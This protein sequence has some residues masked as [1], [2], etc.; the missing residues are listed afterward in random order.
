MAIRPED[1]TLVREHGVPTSPDSTFVTLLADGSISFTERGAELYRFALTWHG[2]S[3]SLLDSV[4]TL[5]QLREL[6]LE[7]KK[8]RVSCE[9]EA[10]E[11]ALKQGRV[12]HK[13][14]ETLRAVL[15]G[16]TEDIRRA[17]AR[18]KA[19][20]A[21]GDNVIPVAFGLRA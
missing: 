9:S 7:I 16:S 21:A 11:R 4:H 17:V 20:E 8:T 10:A 13:S 1:A 12:P 3:P 19:C 18:R 6:S 15:H 2:L 5:D 14:R